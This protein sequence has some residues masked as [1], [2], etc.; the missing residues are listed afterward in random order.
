M[1]RTVLML[2]LVMATLYAQSAVPPPA[3]TYETASIHPSEPNQTG[4]HI[5][6]GPGGGLTT[7][8]TSVKDLITVGWSIPDYRI[9][10]LPG[11]ASSA[12]FDL[13][14][15]PDQQE[16]A[17]TDG[18]KS[19]EFEALLQRQAQRIQAVL[20]DR[21][22]LVLHTEEREMS[23]YS[24]TVAKGGP[25]LTPSSAPMSDRINGGK[26]LIATGFTMK[27]LAADLAEILGRPVNNETALD[28]TYDIKLNW[29][30]NAISNRPQQDDGLSGPSIFTAIT[31]QLG[32]RLESKKG[33]VP[34]YVIDKVE[35]PSGN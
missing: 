30:D 14:F 22:G 2:P 10:G 33:A 23:V 25:R 27:S 29:T 8:N 18:M 9:V 4:A 21:F 5:G 26:S 1:D 3:Y 13:T 24:L 17:F 28:G 19:A 20:R 32:L 12:H 11:W 31:E 16:T 7:R 34:V 6:P 15:T 35:Q